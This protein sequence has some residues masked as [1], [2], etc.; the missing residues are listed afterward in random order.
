MRKPRLIVPLSLLLTMPVLLLAE[1]HRL[2]P[3]TFYNTFSG[4]YPPV[5]RIKPGDRVVTKT[6]DASGTDWN[7]KVV[8]SGPNPETGP[9]YVEGAEPGDTL[10]VTID[11]LEINRATAYS[12]SLL[13]AYTVD[14]AALL[15]RVEREAKRVTW[16]LNKEKGTARLD[17]PDISGLTIE[18][19]LRPMLGCLGVAP[20]RREAISTSTAGPF[21][22]NMDYAG[23]TA[24]VKVMLPVSEPGALLFLGDAH[25][26]QGDGEVVG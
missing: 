21:G 2:V 18:L 8:A 7:G 10:V 3:Q 14:P 23:L 19:P 22:G 25:A 9:F 16:N 11:K 17:A 26:R 12:G 15:A 6:I 20:A 4:A 5:L 1:T 24:G 13:A